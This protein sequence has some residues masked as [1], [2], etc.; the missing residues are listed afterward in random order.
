MSCPRLI[1]HPIYI[2]DIY[3]EE[4]LVICMD[5]ADKKSLQIIYCVALAKQQ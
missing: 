3:D 5:R 2:V 4:E 1:T